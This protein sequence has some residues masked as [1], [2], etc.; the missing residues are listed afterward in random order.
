MNENQR[1]IVREV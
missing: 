1:D